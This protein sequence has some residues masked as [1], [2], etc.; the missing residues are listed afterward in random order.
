L[1]T[2]QSKGFLHR[3]I[4]PD[5]FVMGLKETENEV[6]LLDYGLSRKYT[7]GNSHIK[8][9]ENA[10]LVGTL[11]YCSLN[12]QKGYEQSR[13]DDLESLAYCL[14]YML[15]G[16]LPWQRA[17]DKKGESN[18]KIYNIKLN[19]TTA[20]L[21]AGLPEELKE[22][23]DYCRNLKF[24]EKPHYGRLIKLFQNVFKR[25]SHSKNFDY[26]WN[27]MKCDITKRNCNNE[28]GS[29][30]S[31]FEDDKKDS[32]EV[33]LHLA[34]TRDPT[35]GVSSNISLCKFLKVNV[36]SNKEEKKSHNHS[37]I[38]RKLA[39]PINS[40]RVKDSDYM[41]FAI[42]KRKRC[43][44]QGYIVSKDK[45]LS[46]KMNRR[47]SISPSNFIQSEITERDYALSKG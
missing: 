31:K 12:C 26:D 28:N 34:D 13:R 8:F 42:V 40:S 37:P 43:K 4:K 1:T 17:G 45:E 24:E 23:L 27:I 11:R 29:N 25:V 22:Y 41:I 39:K 47:R 19:V 3:D 14:V 7:N 20:Q 36:T 2:F 16:G 44:S 15:K 5:N 38:K 33:G 10:R 32:Q 9:S 46:K 21:C 18:D 35:S 30:M 6:F